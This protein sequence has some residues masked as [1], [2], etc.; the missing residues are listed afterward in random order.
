MG[1]AREVLMQFSEGHLPLTDP[2]EVLQA[3]LHVV[4]R[5]D[6]RW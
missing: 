6:E 3:V 4:T 2:D 1:A 5:F